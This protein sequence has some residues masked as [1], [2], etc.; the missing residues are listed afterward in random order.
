MALIMPILL[1]LVFGI[2]DFGR[3][4]NAQ[5]TVTEAAREGA[6]AEAL[7]ADPVARANS[8]SS[9]LGTVTVTTD[10]AC[11]ATPD[12]T[13]D[14]QVTVVYAF[15]FLTPVG[16]LAGIFGG[17]GFGGPINVKGKGVMPCMQ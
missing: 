12:T 10:Q 15:D 9:N 2:I 17:G 4:L 8:A 5:V 14:A 16:A 11:P 6:R 13:K 3:L 1:L 7:G